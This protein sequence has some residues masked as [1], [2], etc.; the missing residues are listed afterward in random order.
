M[1]INSIE[2]LKEALEMFKEEAIEHG[3]TEP[4]QK[5]CSWKAFIRD[6]HIEINLPKPIALELEADI[7][8]YGEGMAKPFRG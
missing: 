6:M 1:E 4:I 8:Y 5:L 7:L 2:Q 3:Y